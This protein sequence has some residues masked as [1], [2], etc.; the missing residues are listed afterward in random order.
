M[1]LQAP[2]APA[3]QPTESGEERSFVLMVTP[4]D[5]IKENRCA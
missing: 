4:S 3:P 2:A 5:L 1:R